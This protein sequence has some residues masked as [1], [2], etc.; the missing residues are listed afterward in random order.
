MANKKGVVPVPAGASDVRAFLEAN[1]DRFKSDLHAVRKLVEEL[2]QNEPGLRSIYK[3]YSRGDVQG[4]D[5]LKTA[6]KVRLKFNEFNEGRGLSE[7]SLFDV[8]DIVG[9]T[10]VV[11]YPSGISAVAEALD[12]AIDAKRLKPV[13]MGKSEDVG[14][15]TKHGRALGS[16]G[17]YAC[18]YNVRTVGAGTAR[19]V[20]EIQIKTLLH[21]AWGAKTHDL[22]YKPSGRI[23]E[24]LLTS[25]DLLGSNLANLDQQSDALRTSIVRSSEVRE[26]KRRAVQVAVLGEIAVSTVQIVPDTALRAALEGIQTRVMAMN[27]DT[28]P[29]ISEQAS[30][31]LLG[32]FDDGG[33]APGS[34]LAASTLLCL[35]AAVTRRSVFFE[36]AQDTLDIRESAATDQIEKLQ[37]K[38][39]GMLAPFAGGDTAEAIEFGEVMEAEI[40]AI[41]AGDAKLSDPGKFERMRLSVYSNLAYFHAEIIG[42]HEGD[43]RGSAKCAKDYL[44]RSLALYA[45]VGLPAKGLDSDDKDI[46]DAISGAAPGVAEEVFFALDNEAYVRIQ[47][48]E[49][50]EELRAVRKRLEFLHGLTPPAAADLARLAIDYHDYCARVRLG[51][52]ETFLSR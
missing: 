45:A 22:T 13:S 28:R 23:G 9:F 51:E 6:R 44:T 24:E 10:I 39:N 30:R 34:S 11:P 31:D 37:I 20:I 49:T 8:P 2:S 46:V 42:S 43:K 25:F 21:D 7:A 38:L 35:L 12:R 15:R 47:S 16:K 50:E 19:P 52:L 33:G 1:R 27:E 5:E 41:D 3:I 36:Q 26:R 17:Y 32:I 29:E 18:H 14:I 40:A 4:F 48:A